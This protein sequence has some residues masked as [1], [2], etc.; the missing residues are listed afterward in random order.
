MP[1]FPM[2]PRQPTPVPPAAPF[3]SFPAGTGSATFLPPPPNDLPTGPYGPPRNIPQHEITTSQIVQERQQAGGL[4]NPA[5]VSRYP[6]PS[7]F[8]PPLPPLPPA[9]PPRMPPQPPPFNYQEPLPPVAPINLPV[10]GL[11]HVLGSDQSAHTPRRPS[12][13]T[14]PFD[15][16]Y[17][18]RLLNE[19]PWEP[20]PPGG[21][22]EGPQ[23]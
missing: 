18:D 3:F 13:V 5:Q 6:S 19:R 20:P 4:P 23:Y 15:P 2:G 17:L 14:Q 11:P 10:E 12:P 21:Y 7:P 8:S 9:T 1:Q 16:A 22:V